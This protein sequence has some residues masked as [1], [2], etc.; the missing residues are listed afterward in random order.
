MALVNAFGAIALDE[1]VQ[2][3]VDKLDAGINV[4]PA[5]ITGKFRESF[6]NFVP[7]VNWNLTKDS[8]DIVQLDGN[9]VSASYVVI[10][11]DPL[12]VGSVTT[13]ETIAS[14]PMPTEMAVGMS[15]SQRILGQELAVEVVSTETPSPSTPD[16]AIATISQS[17]T[18]L[19]VVTDGPHGVVP[20]QRMGIYGCNDSRMNYP[21][22]VVSGIQSAT[23]FTCT[24]GPG[25]TIP[26]GT[27]GAQ[28]TGYV[29]V[30]SAMAGAQN[31]VSEI[32]ENTSLTNASVYSR[33]ASGDALPS[34]TT[35]GN[36]TITV[37]SSAS[38][39]S[40]NSPY[41]YAF[42]PT[43][44]YRF[45][46]QADRAQF[47]DATVDTAATPSSRLLRTQVVPDPN[48]QYKLRF[49]FTNNKGLTV[50]S[51]KIVSAVK[52][53]STTATITTD[54]PHGLT[55]GS[56][57]VIYGI[58]NQTSF[59]NQT[60]QVVVASTPTSTT[61]TVAF[62]ASATAT[63]GGGM[64][65]QV[66]GANVPAA[67]PALAVQSAS[68]A[69]NELNLSASANWAWSVGDYVNVYGVRNESTGAD[70]GV[71][72]VYRVVD[73]S[74]TATRLAPI[75][76]ATTLPA[77]SPTNCG[78]TVIKRTDLR[79]AFVRIFDYLRERVEVQPNGAAAASVPVVVTATAP[80]SGSL[81]PISSNTFT[82][83]TSTNLA[84][85]ATFTGSSLNLASSTTGGTVYFTSINVAVTHLAGL[86]PGT[87]IYEV[88]S[89]TSST[90]PTTWYPAFTIPIPSVNGWQSFTLP[91]STRWY[92]FR[93]VNGATAQTVFRLSTMTQY[94]GAMSNALSF[95][96]TITYPLSVT[97]L[98][99]GST[100]TGPT[101]DFGDTMSVY[102]TI[103][104][105]AFASHDSATNG[106]KIQVSRDGTNWR[107]AVSATVTAN[108]LTRIEWGLIY[109]YVRVVYTNGA[110]TQTTFE[111]FANADV[112]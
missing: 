59:A 15:F 67:F 48:K 5:N 91:V 82:L 60:S 100:F 72:G 40:I 65:A 42:L 63:S 33:S 43:T 7:G 34:G 31:G 79:L 12:S 98:T 112:R 32:F 95:P 41:T 51:G 17:S 73:V 8:N 64:V 37:G 84:A 86:T 14:Y 77:L 23:Q 88:G 20:G 58:R 22:L 2:D 54:G 26:S 52:S 76:P 18:T 36:Q 16:V 62:G 25:G 9:A 108:T 50:P 102:K 99:G 49:R 92:R 89:E 94:N 45:V 56:Y 3:V 83:P 101:L 97:N 75:D 38:V 81:T 27:I 39:Q 46:L 69:S 85:N 6:E 55:T 29:Y 106:F 19:T 103:T 74:T 61:F 78:G 70:L 28:T 96:D 80:V 105:Q 1:T 11:K 13:L 47:M 87:L 10:S 35:S 104:A 24:A 4:T 30:R 68:V 110:T 107:D 109:R 66:N 53:G 44:E 90:A 93:F 57:V 21:S 71:D 111:L